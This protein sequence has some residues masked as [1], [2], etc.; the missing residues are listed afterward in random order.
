LYGAITKDVTSGKV[1]WNIPCDPSNIPATINNIPRNAGEGLLCY[2]IRALNLTGASGIVTVNGTQTLTN[3]TLTAPVINSPTINNLT[4]TGTLA[5]PAGSITSAMIA[6][7]TI[8][9]ADINASAA[10]ATS[11]LA[12]VTATGS[13]TPRTLANRFTDVINA[14][15]FGVVGDGVTDDTAALQAALDYAFNQSG[16]RVV[17]SGGMRCLIDSANLW[18]NSNVTLVGPHS[19]IGKNRRRE[20]D[21]SKV[22]GALI[23]NPA[24]TIQLGYNPA[25][26]RS[27]FSSGI[28]GLYVL[29]KNI[30]NPTPTPFTGQQVLDLIAG[31][32][33]TGITLGN[34]TIFINSAPSTG[35]VSGII[36][37][38]VNL[39][40]SPVTGTNNSTTF[41]TAVAAAIN[42]NSGSTGH[43]ATSNGNRLNIYVQGQNLSIGAT[44][45]Y[46][47]TG[48]G[49]GYWTGDDNAVRNCCIVGFYQGIYGNFAARYL[50]ENIIA[51]NTN[52]IRTTNIYDIGRISNVHFNSII[53]EGA[54]YTGNQYIQSNLRSGYGFAFDKGND[55]SQA[56]NSFCFGYFVGWYV[57]AGS[58]RLIGCGSDAHGSAIVAG[59][60]AFWITNEAID[61][62][63]IGCQGCSHEIT[64][65]IDSTQFTTLESCA[66][67]SNPANQVFADKGDVKILNCEFF[68]GGYNGIIATGSTLQSAL[69]AGNSFN[70]S[71]AAYS[72]NA[73]SKNKVNILTSN[74][75]LGSSGLNE[76]T[77]RRTTS[78][79]GGNGDG[80]YAFAGSGYK[81]MYYYAN[82]S[83]STPTAVT[84]G[85]TIGTNIYGAH[86]GTSF[87]ERVAILRASVIGSVSTGIVPTG[88]IF[89]TTDNAGTQTDR[90]VVDGSAV[91]PVT[92]KGMTLGT[93]SVAWN[94]IYNAYGTSS[95]QTVSWTSGT[96]SP[97]GV[98]TANVGSLYTDN[99]G[100]TST[101]LYV[102]TSG[103]GNTGWTAK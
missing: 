61:T 81:Q 36:V 18:I 8:V 10:I 21:F 66:G 63:L 11:K 1:V 19:K 68:D 45:T 60:K 100:S 12:P 56:V 6:D 74:I 15:D 93:P 40:S 31:Y 87:V 88:F 102:K 39:L 94:G 20:A 78:Q 92:N 55:W 13:T 34:A 23:V 64:Y 89:S 65:Y 4:A 50:L 101:T 48:L 7:G 43:T 17:I 14:K 51:D 82:G 27:S 47:G 54:T 79:G 44:F 24:Y 3:K 90:F 86:D 5:L 28:E 53:G 52:G 67:W 91:S 70:S 96:G 72:L 69:I 33:G 95:N 32:S 58:V 59:S 42:A 103:T 29:N 35:A 57:E 2:I 77:A 75:Y 26:D 9:N 97:N 73:S 30:C 25:T 37:R 62:Q 76:F 99:A 46:T 41:M 98:V 71:S 49:F 38:G 22:T 85:Q 16:G 84:S 83:P 80:V